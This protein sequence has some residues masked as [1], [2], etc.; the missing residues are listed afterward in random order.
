MQSELIAL[1]RDGLELHRTTLDTAGAL[2][3]EKIRSIEG[4]ESAEWA[5]QGDLVT[6]QL[7]M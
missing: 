1:T 2:T 6:L 4:V 3:V 5:P 7:Q